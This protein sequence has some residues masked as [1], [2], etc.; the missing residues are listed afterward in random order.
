MGIQSD[1][2]KVLKSVGR[3]QIEAL[4]AH[5]EPEKFNR[6]ILLKF[7][8]FS[9]RMC[10]RCTGVYVGIVGT[11]AAYLINVIT[12]T[13]AIENIM[14]LF[15]PLP[16]FLDWSL[17][18]LKIWE[19]NNFTRLASGLLLGAGYVTM[20]RRFLFSP[21]DSTLWFAVIA[22]VALA[23]IVFWVHDARKKLAI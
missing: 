23:I 10:T 2:N 22:Y 19:G 3:E 6:T 20:W 13:R 12:P 7:N 9:L 11:V 1:L 17:N 4:L 15:L 18:K 14:I 21:F 16:A 8:T 5:H